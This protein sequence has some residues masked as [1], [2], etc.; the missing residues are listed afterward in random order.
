MEESSD[1]CKPKNFYQYVVWFYRPLIGL[2]TETNTIGYVGRP[3]VLGNPYTLKAYTRTDAIARDWIPGCGSSGNGRARYTPP[4][5]Q[6]PAGIRRLSS[7]PSCVGVHHSAAHA[8]VIREAVL[9]IVQ[10]WL[11]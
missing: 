1:N 7:S 3:T 4:V 10:H 2:Y 5:L 11:V 6:L 9:G 8:E